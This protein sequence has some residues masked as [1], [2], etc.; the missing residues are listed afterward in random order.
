VSNLILW[1][2]VQ[3]HKCFIESRTDCIWAVSK[4][5][6]FAFKY[7]EA[8]LTQDSYNETQKEKFRIIQKDLTEAKKKFEFLGKELKVCRDKF[9]SASEEAK[10]S[11]MSDLKKHFKDMYKPFN[12]LLKD[13]RWLHEEIR[14]IK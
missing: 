14:G 4:L 6:E 10:E 7:V 12:N 13:V 11:A 1:T 3:L 8:K 9:A 5:L 2:K